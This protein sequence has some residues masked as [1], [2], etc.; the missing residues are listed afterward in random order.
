MAFIKLQFRAGVNRDQTNYT[1]EGGWFACDKI[2]FRSGFPQK[3][4]GWMRSTSETFLGVCR[5]LFGWITSFGDN[6]LAVGTS[7]KVYINTGSQYYDITPLKE[8][9]APG[10]VT[11]SAVTV[12]PYSSIITVNDTGSNVEAGDFVTFSGAISLGGNITAAVLN[13]EY[14]VYESISANLS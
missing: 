5:Q 10:A 13:Q 12:G 9:T 4:G 8:T 14:E 1:N 2:R 7:K 3:L 11:F 6:F